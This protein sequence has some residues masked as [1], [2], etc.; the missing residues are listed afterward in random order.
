MVLGSRLGRGKE[1]GIFEE[2][3]V[4]SIWNLKKRRERK[5]EKQQPAHRGSRRPW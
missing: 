3:N 1:L 4:D 2:Q 5:I